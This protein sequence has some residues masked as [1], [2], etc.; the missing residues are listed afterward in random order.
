MNKPLTIT[1]CHHCKTPTL[2]SDHLYTQLL[3]LNALTPTQ[4]AHAWINDQPTYELRT[5]GTRQHPHYR[6]PSPRAMTQLAHTI[7]TQ[8][9]ATRTVLTPHT[10]PGPTNPDIHLTT[11]Q[12]KDRDA[13]QPKQRPRPTDTQE[14]P[15]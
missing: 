6:N 12:P 3:E 15:F 2:R 5:H 1:A 13:F 7:T 11:W 10:C 9:P 8:Q 4:E 14:V